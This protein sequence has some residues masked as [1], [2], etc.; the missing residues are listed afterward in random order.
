[1]SLHI[2]YLQKLAKLAP[3]MNQFSIQLNK[4]VGFYKLF[5]RR[6]MTA[7]D[8]A[9]CTT[10]YDGIRR[11]TTAQKLGKLAPKMNQLSIQLNKNVGF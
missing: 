3:K 2:T 4:N 9:R 6:C 11:R 7:H 5:E 1:M 8:G 10:A